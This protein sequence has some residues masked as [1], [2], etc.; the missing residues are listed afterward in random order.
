VSTVFE[1]FA[2]F[3]QI[4]PAGSFLQLH[5]GVELPVHPQEVPRA[6][7]LRT[8]VGKTFAQEGGLGRRW[9]PIVE[10]L[11]DRSLI[12]SASTDW[13]VLPQMQ[14]PVS[15]RMHILANVGFRLPL[16]N[17]ADRQKQLMFYVL[18]DWV[19]GGL[20]EGW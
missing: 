9:T 7:Y 13:D 1:G 4:L 5:T 3:G 14:I 17:T 8:A 20:K 11:A 6:Y 2:A 12:S 15:R 18:W 19:D 10:I 16:N